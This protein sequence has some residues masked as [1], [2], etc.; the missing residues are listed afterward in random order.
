MLV[1]CSKCFNPPCKLRRH[2]RGSDAQARQVESR[3]V[4]LGGALQLFYKFKLELDLNHGVLGSLSRAPEVPA[5]SPCRLLNF[6][7]N[8]SVNVSTPQPN[9]RTSHLTNL[10]HSNLVLILILLCLC[11]M[12]LY[13]QRSTE[14]VNIWKN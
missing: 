5:R 11:R 2:R 3:S 6:E 13:L 12:N 4:E 10:K 7:C 8:S 14:K 1:K 9:K